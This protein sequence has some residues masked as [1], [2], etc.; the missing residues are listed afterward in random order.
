MVLLSAQRLVARLTPSNKV[1][2]LCLTPTS[3]EVAVATAQG[4]DLRVV[5]S[6]DMLSPERLQQLVEE[7]EV[8]GLLMGGSALFRTNGQTQFGARKLISQLHGVD[9]EEGMMGLQRPKRLDFPIVLWREGGDDPKDLVH[10]LVEV[11]KQQD[12]T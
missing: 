6:G 2:A 1:M 5:N 3:T 10:G 9:Y 12:Q 4:E 11:A 7:H 8:S